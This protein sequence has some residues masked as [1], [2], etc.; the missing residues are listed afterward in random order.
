MFGDARAMGAWQ[1]LHATILGVSVIDG[2]PGRCCFGWLQ[3]PVGDV[4]VPG[5]ELGWVI[6]G[7]LAEDVSAEQHH[8]GSQDRF[9]AVKD[10]WCGCQV[11]KELL[12]DMTTL[13]TNL[14]MLF[15]L[16][17]FQLVK[18]AADLTHFTIAMDGE[19][20]EESIVGVVL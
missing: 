9:H 3:P 8:V 5:N 20:V 1:H 6:L 10:R 12:V 15:A 19:C 7:I 17:R 18:L 14:A 16:T 2:V 11:P 4:L 13:Q